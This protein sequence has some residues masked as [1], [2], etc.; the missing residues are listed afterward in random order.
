MDSYRF[1]LAIVKPI[2]TKGSKIYTY[3]IV[4]LFISLIISAILTS[5]NEPPHYSN[6]F[7]VSL[8]VI[9]QLIYAFRTHAVE[10]FERIG[11]IIFSSTGLVIEYNRESTSYS[12]AQIKHV[13]IKFV[14]TREDP[15][16]SNTM[17]GLTNKEGINNNIQIKSQSGNL[18]KY[19]VLIENR[20]SMRV[21][22][23]IFSSWP[24]EKVRRV[25]R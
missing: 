19:Q 3:I 4:G 7:F 1:K 25:K 20:A 16:V 13:K 2:K 6:L 11:S 8:L 22:N 12:L 21:L 18:V 10:E 14:E 9:F 15:V 24:Q 17:R 5:D 23:K